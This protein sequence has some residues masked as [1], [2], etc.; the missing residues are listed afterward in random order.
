MA[1]SWAGRLR[2]RVPGG[3]RP[4]FR[5]TLRLRLALLYAALLAVSAGALGAAAVIF[6]PNFLVH[7]SFRAA[8]GSPGAAGCQAHSCT[9]PGGGLAQFLAG[10]A[11]SHNIGGGLL[12][13][14]ILAVLALGAGWLLAGR[15]VRP[16]LAITSSAR[17]ISASNLHQRL[18]VSGPGDE[19][20]ELGETL[21]DLFARL[22]ASFESQR[23]FV[24]NASHELR[25]PLAAER[26]L[27]QVALA[28]PGASTETLRSACRE[29][30]ALGEQQETLIGALLTL[31]TSERGLE[32]RE[33]FD[34]AGIARK[35]ITDQEA[36]AGR[37]G[38]QIDAVLQPAAATGDPGLAESLVANLVDNAV[39]HNR[40]DGRVQVSVTA[41]DGQAVLAVSNT[42]EP[43]PPAEVSRLF[44]PFQR[45]GAD[46]VRGAGGHGLGLAIVRAIADA[47]GAVLAAAPGPGGGLAVQVTFPPGNAEPA[48]P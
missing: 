44:Q 1:R 30:L 9:A 37:R 25:T 29:A 23:R 34:L 45:L 22:E 39:R 16:L 46:R 7:S 6:K 19:F 47:H 20:T 17:H 42:G 38:I 28:D 14:A 18:Q 10:G 21:D 8:Q 13:L 41:S 2:G 12:L 26:T 35:V 15:I 5:R 32:R 48:R 24:A 27:L 43:V 3:P 36:A 40:P 4:A 11:G 31:A 33:R